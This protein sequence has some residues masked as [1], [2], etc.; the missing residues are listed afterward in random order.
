M[1]PRQ[2]DIDPRDGSLVNMLPSLEDACRE[3]GPEA[4]PP[5][6]L[7]AQS[8]LIEAGDRRRAAPIGK[9]E[10]AG[11]TGAR[12]DLTAPAPC[13]RCG[14]TEGFV[15]QARIGGIDTFGCLVCKGS[16]AA[17]LPVGQT[18]NG[19]AASAGVVRGRARVVKSL[20]ELDRLE[21]GDIL[22]CL[23]MPPPWTPRLAVAAG[24][25]TD[26]GGV[27]SQ[28]ATWARESRVPCV[29]ATQVATAVIP[30]RAIVTVDGSEGIVIIEAG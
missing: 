1:N 24:V 10:R 6:T 30:D 22:V 18:I 15:W 7:R 4:R 2:A 8:G 25:V 12:S 27:L 3:A 23:T 5:P 29:V 16:M 26:V 19:R 9:R 20:S 13:N 21:D 28:A 14:G 17:A 11:Q